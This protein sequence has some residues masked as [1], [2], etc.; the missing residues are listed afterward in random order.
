MVSNT[1]WTSVGEL[2]IDAQDLA[3]GRLLLEGLGQLAVARLQ[4]REQPHVLDGDH[5]L[6]GE[7]LEEGDL[8]LREELRLGATDVDRADRDTFS[9]QGDAEDGA[10][11]HAPRVLAALREFVHFGLHVCDVDG[12]PVQHGSARDRPADERE[13][14]LADGADGDRA[15]MGD[16]EE[17][18]AVPAPDGGIERSHRRAALSAMVSNTGWTSV[19]ELRDDAQDLAG[20]RLLL[21]RLGQ[22]VRCAPPVP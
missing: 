10:E 6:V 21:Q 8:P 11:A 3:R 4:L 15:V 22:V 14:K 9:H 13:G 2:A 5:R 1:G 20:R 7:G 19:G 17:P 12:P 16:Q 18:V